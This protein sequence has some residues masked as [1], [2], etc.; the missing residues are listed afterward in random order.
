MSVGLVPVAW[1]WEQQGIAKTLPRQLRGRVTWGSPRPSSLQLS[2]QKHELLFEIMLAHGQASFL[3]YHEVA[4]P[5]L[6]PDFCDE[7]ASPT[8]PHIHQNVLSYQLP[9]LDF[10]SSPSFAFCLTSI[11]SVLLVGLLRASLDHSSIIPYCLNP[12]FVF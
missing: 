4:S 2:T 12:S 6:H 3:L 9:L 5:S 7:A 1:Q 11:C 8:A 10:Q